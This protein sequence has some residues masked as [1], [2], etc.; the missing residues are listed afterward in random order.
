MILAIAP[1]GRPT[2]ISWV[3]NPLSISEFDVPPLS[4]PDLV[5]DCFVRQCRHGEAC[6]HDANAVLCV[7]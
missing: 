5:A 1:K 3:S 4:N 2:G 7:A 6:M